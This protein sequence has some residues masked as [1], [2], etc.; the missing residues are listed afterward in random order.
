MWQE[1]PRDHGIAICGHRTAT[2]ALPASRWTTTTPPDGQTR[3]VGGE[4]RTASEL[5]DRAGGIKSV[6][7]ATAELERWMTSEGLA[8]VRDG[9]LVVTPKA[10]EL[11][12]ALRLES[13]GDGVRRAIPIA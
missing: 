8:T 7:V 3:A 2:D 12:D 9:R 11:V 5:L 10:V 13:R 6:R 4:A 1:E